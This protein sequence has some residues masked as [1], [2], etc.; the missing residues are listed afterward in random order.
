MRAFRSFTSR[1]IGLAFWKFEFP[2]LYVLRH[3][4][5]RDSRARSEG[6]ESTR[7][8]TD[9]AFC[10]TFQFLVLILI[11]I[12]SH[13]CVNAKPRQKQKH[14]P[15]KYQQLIQQLTEDLTILVCWSA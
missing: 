7:P 9:M 11:I 6:D 15:G 2:H 8:H 14:K 1:R 3:K 4:R 12:N 5:G 10:P 13:D